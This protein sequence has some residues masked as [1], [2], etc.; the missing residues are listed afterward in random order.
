[1]SD[2]KPGYPN[3]YTWEQLLQILDN[4]HLIE[5]IVGGDAPEKKSNDLIKATNNED[6][7]LGINGLSF[8]SMT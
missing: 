6:N 3:P 8:K 5:N 2:A 7:K 1:M 4:H